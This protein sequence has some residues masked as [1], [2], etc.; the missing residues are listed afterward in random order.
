MFLI[1]DRGES[2]EEV[3]LLPSHIQNS[4]GSTVHACLPSAVLCIVAC[5]SCQGSLTLAVSFSWNTKF[6]RQ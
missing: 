5:C 1:R 2:E 4:S 6:W 3:K